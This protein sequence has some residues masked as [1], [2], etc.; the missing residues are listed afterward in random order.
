[1]CCR[2]F[3]GR[4]FWIVLGFLLL[5]P[6]SLA[7]TDASG[8][9]AAQASSD[10]NSDDSSYAEYQYILS[11]SEAD[12]TGTASRWQH[13]ISAENSATDFNADGTI[14]VDWRYRLESFHN[15]IDSKGS[16]CQLLIDVVDEKQDWYVYGSYDWVFSRSRP[17]QD[18]GLET[19][20]SA[21]SVENVNDSD[22]PSAIAWHLKSS[23]EY[24]Y[25]EDQQA[26]R[27]RSAERLMGL[28]FSLQRDLEHSASTLSW[29]FGSRWQRVKRRDKIDFLLR[30]PDTVNNE[31]DLILPFV[32]LRWLF[33]ATSVD[34]Q[35]DI[36]YEK[37]IGDDEQSGV[38][39]FLEGG[40]RETNFQRAQ[41]QLF[42]QWWLH[43][44]FYKDS[45]WQA[46]L[47]YELSGFEGFGEALISDG[48]WPVGGKYSVRGY[49]DD[50]SG[51]D[52]GQLLRVE[53]GY[54]YLH[55]AVNKLRTFAFFDAG[56]YQ[57][58]ASVLPA[59]SRFIAQGE[60]LALQSSGLG[61]ELALR[62]GLAAELI[63]GRVMKSVSDI[64]EQ[65]DQRFHITLSWTF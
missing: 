1:M 54:Y 18:A 33:S 64:A 49:D 39:L 44:Y 8:R 28:S 21:A 29:E 53:F 61:L 51:A 15:D 9:D 50:F 34:T 62:S 25:F 16:R 5:S 46:F 6:P 26:V 4:Q 24:A 59:D 17:M 30:A 56:R 47:A 48:Q 10:Q 22:S 55:A 7:Q 37:N 40:E 20:F 43:R 2:Q 45:S 19:G 63:W 52:S 57:I 14:D 32:H 12:L 3:W 65:G 11:L 38:E 13:R 58:E 42:Q 36:R 35:L 23:A 31:K 60:N 27:L 41:A